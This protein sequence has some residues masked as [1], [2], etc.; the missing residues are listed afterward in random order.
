MTL[1]MHHTRLCNFVAEE[2]CNWQN[3]YVIEFTLVGLV[4][5]IGM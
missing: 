3:A 1:H 5:F 2:N 4:S